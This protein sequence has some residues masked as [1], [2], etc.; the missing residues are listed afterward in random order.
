[1]EEAEALLAL[2]R[3]PQRAGGVKRWKRFEI[4]VE[5]ITN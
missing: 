3:I 2:P 1:M 5:L 4:I